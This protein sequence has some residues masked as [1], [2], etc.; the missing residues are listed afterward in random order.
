MKLLNFAFFVS[1]LLGFSIYVVTNYSSNMN[2]D[3]IHLFG[4][5][6]LILKGV[7]YFVGGRRKLGAFLFVCSYIPFSLF[8]T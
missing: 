4:G 1:C 6:A 3:L 2:R 8:F 5:I 7:H